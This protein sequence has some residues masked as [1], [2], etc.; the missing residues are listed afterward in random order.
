MSVYHYQ[1]D[2]DRTLPSIPCQ[3]PDSPVLPPLRSARPLQSAIR[4][5]G[6]TLQ[7]SGD[8][9]CM[10][11]LCRGHLAEVRASGK[12]RR[13]RPLA[14]PFRPRSRAWQ[15]V[16]ASRHDN[17]PFCLQELLA[18]IRPAA[19]RSGIPHHTCMCC[20]SDWLGGRNSAIRREAATGLPLWKIFATVVPVL[21]PT[22]SDGHPR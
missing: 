6:G 17:S 18:I 9:Q 14:C 16:V 1:R 10:E 22:V 8:L 12:C 21:S 15:G 2:P 20:T 7:S 4:N 11:D 3:F 13:T 19:S 5:Y